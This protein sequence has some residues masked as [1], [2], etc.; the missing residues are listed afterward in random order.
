MIRVEAAFFCNRAESEQT[1]LSLNE[2][3][4]RKLWCTFETKDET[5]SYRTRVHPIVEMPNQL[6]PMEKRGYPQA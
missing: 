3:A 6:L 5:R 2:P 1:I 4:S